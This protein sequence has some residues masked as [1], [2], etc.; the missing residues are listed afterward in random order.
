MAGTGVVA[1]EGVV[2]RAGV[3]AGADVMAVGSPA[4]NRRILDA[5]DSPM[6]LFASDLTGPDFRFPE[7]SG[8]ML[9]N[10]SP[11][12]ERLGVRRAQKVFRE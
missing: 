5:R 3:M 1:G 7:G 6:W 12:I 2:A 9:P 4:S 8:S 11:A 10:I